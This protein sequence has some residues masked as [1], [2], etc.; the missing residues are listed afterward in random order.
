M[1][2]NSE[3]AHSLHI[4]WSRNPKFCV[5]YSARVILITHHN[6]DRVDYIVVP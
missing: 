5:I 3:M 4:A 1:L 6:S 2:T